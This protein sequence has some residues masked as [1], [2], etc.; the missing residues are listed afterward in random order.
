MRSEQIKYGT[1]NN[2]SSYY[3]NKISHL[4]A[5]ILVTLAYLLPKI[6]NT[7]PGDLTARRGPSKRKALGNGPTHACSRP[8]L[9]KLSTQYNGVFFRTR[10]CR[11]CTGCRKEKQVYIYHNILPIVVFISVQIKQL[12]LAFLRHSSHTQQILHGHRISH[13]CKMFKLLKTF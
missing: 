11:W 8:A 3:S 2:D 6:G 13:H 9:I 1:P 5:A 10:V 4:V 12:L 7:G